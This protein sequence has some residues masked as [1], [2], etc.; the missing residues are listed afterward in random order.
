MTNDVDP[1][2]AKGGVVELL[3]EAKKSGLIRHIGFSVHS[4]VAA[5]A[6]LDRFPFDSILMPVNFATFHVGQFGP[7]IFA[8]ARRRNVTI[9]ALKSMA[10]Q[11]WPADYTKEH[12]QRQ[13]FSKCWYQP[14]TD[15]V[16]TELALRFTLSQ[17]IAAALPPGE[18]ELFWR[19]VEIARRF[20]PITEPELQTLRHMAD[21][22]N[23][24]FG[25]AP[26]TKAAAH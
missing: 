2:F 11:A 22:I 19:A 24:L 4:A 16:E 12:P 15:P 17:P 3:Q 1:A 9:L 7:S 21:A 5:L 10:R 14:L 18:E 23:P 8:E 20:Q 6:A 25:Q 13:R 26:P